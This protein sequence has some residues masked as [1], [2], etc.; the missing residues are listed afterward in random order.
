MKKVR[1]KQGFFLVAEMTGGVMEFP[2]I[3]ANNK[4]VICATS[5]AKAVEAYNAKHMCTYYYGACLAYII[6]RKLKVRDK[7][8][9]TESDIEALKKV[10]KT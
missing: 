5:E 8:L 6:G 10:A 1:S 3:H 4:E 7:H 9:T 2:C